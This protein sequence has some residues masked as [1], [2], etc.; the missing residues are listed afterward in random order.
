M[1]CIEWPLLWQQLQYDQEAEIKS[2][3]KEVQQ[4]R[5]K[6]SETI[7]KLK[8]QFLQEKKQFQE[9]SDSRIEAMAKQAN[10][11]KIP[12]EDTMNIWSP[13]YM[14]QFSF[15]IVSM[16]CGMQ[17]ILWSLQEILLY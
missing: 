13:L 9:Q 8:V 15:M 16:F 10:Q 4:M 6:H 11:V 12:T 3:E 5:A 7:Q 1:F 17:L 2:L 14:I